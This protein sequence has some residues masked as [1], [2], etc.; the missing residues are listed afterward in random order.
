MATRPDATGWP[1]LLT[2]MPERWLDTCQGLLG[3]SQAVTDRWLTS[4][5][6]QLQSTL[7]AWGKLARCTELGEAA[8]IQQEWLQQSTERLAAEL[9]GYQEPLSAAAQQAFAG[10]GDRASVPARKPNKAA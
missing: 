3:A 7:E 9:A 5:S 10:L 1:G 4:R 6:Q 8:R 2:Q